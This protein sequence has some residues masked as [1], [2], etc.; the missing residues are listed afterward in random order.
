MG[1][2]QINFTVGMYSSYFYNV[3]TILWLGNKN[4]PYR[5]TYVFP[6]TGGK[7]FP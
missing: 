5:M 2:C 6:K 4:Q 7:Y 3:M 1:G